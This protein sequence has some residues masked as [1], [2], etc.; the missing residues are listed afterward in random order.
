MTL[1]PITVQD[2]RLS[3]LSV[4][5]KSLHVGSKQMTMGVFR[6]LTQEQILS[7]EMRL[8]G[9]P[10]GRVNYFWEDR[11]KGYGHL[12]IVWQKDDE[13]RRACIDKNET[14]QLDFH[15]DYSAPE[16]EKE[17]TKTWVKETVAELAK[18][19]LL[20]IAV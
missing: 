14:W 6:Q 17:K 2:A 5:I 19:P 9:I 20:F 3:T 16:H 7:N 11:C 13:L 1:T 12:H 15:Y 4:S 10:W 8:L 18:L